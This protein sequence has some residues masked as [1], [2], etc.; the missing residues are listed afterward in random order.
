MVPRILVFIALLSLH[1]MKLSAQCTLVIDS[2]VTE[3]VTCNGLADGNIIVFASGGNGAISFSGSAGGGTIVSPNQA[4]DASNTISTASGSG[5]TNRWWSPSSCGG[6]AF[7]QYSVSQGCPAGSAQFAGNSSG[8]AGCFLRSPQL[9]MNGIDDVVVTFDLTNSFSA[10]RPNDR[11]RFY[12]WV[13]NGYLSVPAEYSVNGISGQFYNFSQAGNCADITVTVDLSTIPANSRSDFFF[14]I[15]ANCQY[16]NC[17]PYLAIVDNIVISEPAPTQSSNVFSNLAPGTYPITVSD[18][19][20]C[21]ITLT[22]PILITQPTPLSVSSN[23]VAATTIGGN[24]GSATALATGGNGSYLYSWNSNPAQTGSTAVGLSAGN[25]A[26]TVSDSKGCTAVSQ[27]TVSEPSCVGF[28]I[29]NVDVV[30]PTCSGDSDGSFSIV[31]SGPNSGIQYAINDGAFQNSG[32]FS[33]LSAGTYVLQG[34]DGAGCTTTYSINPLVISNPISP[35][36]DIVLNGSELS[37]GAFNT[38][39]WFLNSE[40]IEGA[41]NSTLPITSNGTYS[42]QV[43]DANNCIG[44]SE[45]FEVLTTNLAETSINFSVHP[46]PFS[47]YISLNLKGNSICKV[48]SIYNNLGAMVWNCEACEKSLLIPATE[49]PKGVYW[50]QISDGMQATKK[51]MLIKN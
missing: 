2:V 7:F 24:Q 31:A 33:D 18:A 20:G 50:I 42:V 16:N 40:L 43:T 39:Q 49:F 19:S 3:N 27:V 11:L 46:N 6:G 10:S 25:Y 9:N 51:K 45:V 17:T 38:Y 13:N 37:T 30:S 41:N 35:Q 44:V 22:N 28:A 12:A 34:L 14:Y 21:I 8:F 47:D 4:F 32:T 23:S 15:E 48:I 29:V 36:P 1:F 26:V 5:P